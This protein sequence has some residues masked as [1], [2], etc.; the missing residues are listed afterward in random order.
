VLVTKSGAVVDC[1]SW[2]IQ[3]RTREL[4]LA[5]CTGEP[6]GLD[7]LLGAAN[8]RTLT[9]DP[10][11]RVNRKVFC[12]RAMPSSEP[13]REHGHAICFFSVDVES[14]QSQM[15]PGSIRLIHFACL[16]VCVVQIR[17]ESEHYHDLM[18]QLARYQKVSQP[19]SRWRVASRCVPCVAVSREGYRRQHHPELRAIDN[20]GRQSL[21]RHGAQ[22]SA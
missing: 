13:V 17:Q 19:T 4:P 7:K 20:F 14:R 8:E 22:R 5:T 16:R 2:R 3:S 18:K 15:V 6:L 11:E 12:S 1:Q 10:G 9:L 21:C